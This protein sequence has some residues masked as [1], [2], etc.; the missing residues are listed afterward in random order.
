M[1]TGN[2]MNIK[3]EKGR[4]SALIPFIVFAAFYLGLSLWTGDFYR[5]PMTV[6]FLVASAV[7][8]A[9]RPRDIAKNINVYAR[10]MGEPDIMIMSLIFILAGAFAAIAKGMGAVDSTVAIAQNI[11]PES[12]LLP[13]M[14]IVAC[15]LSLAIGTSC[16]TIAALTPIAIS[17]TSSMNAAPAVM[18]GAVIG[19]A[20][21]GDNISMISDTTIAATRTMNISMK[22]KF[23]SNISFALPAAAVT[24]AIYIFCSRDLQGASSVKPLIGLT[25]F[26][27]ITPYI[28]ILALA[29]YGIN[30]LVLLFGASVFAAVIGITLK[31]FD[32]WGALDLLGKGCLNMAETLFVAL[33]AGGLLSIVKHLGGVAFIMQKIEQCV[34]SKT[35]CELG[36]A[37]LVSA[38]NLF[39]ANNTVAIVITG[40]IARELAER[41]KCSPKRIASILD[42]SS[43]II[44]GVIPY[45]AQLLIATGI[46][47]GANV[48]LS[49]AE[50]MISC[51]YQQ[52]LLIALIIWIFFRRNK[53]C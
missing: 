8:L 45:G 27:R 18:V 37:L 43:C 34:K 10:G 21:F 52:L 50:L 44:Q 26:I 20:M 41:Y 11:L 19:G 46:A 40:P 36:T 12:L 48:K 47:H 24:L 49:A 14:F 15:F 38:V 30:V 31:T 35:G 4:F 28:L 22:D 7:A 51:R 32:F 13:G 39:T 53:N 17:M 29:V 5:V 1:N 33:L 9:M 42:A 23:F 25:D 16:G 6:A 3:T 2:N